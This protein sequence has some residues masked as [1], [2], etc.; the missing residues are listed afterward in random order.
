MD[1]GSGTKN[2]KL[3][4]KDFFDVK[5]APYITFH[6]AKIVQ[7]GPMTFDI[8]GTFAIRGVSK[9]ET[10]TFTLHGT[11]GSGEGE[12]QGTLAFDHK[13]YGMNSGIPFIKIADRVEV[14]VDLKLKRVSG[15][16]GGLQ[17]IGHHLHARAR[18]T[19]GDLRGFRPFVRIHQFFCKTEVPY[20]IARAVRA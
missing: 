7:T 16:P 1:T 2:S 13:G 10:L 19:S 11:K 12:V 3:K 17:A 4:S 9:P 20:R 8:P 5:D 14:S 15:S 18:E 6:S